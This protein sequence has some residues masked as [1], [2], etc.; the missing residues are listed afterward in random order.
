MNN[1]KLTLFSATNLV[2]ANIIGA[3]IF[4]ISGYTLGSVPSVFGLLIIW[5]IGG[6]LALCGALVYGELSSIMPKSGGEYYY[7]SRIYHPILGFLSGFISLTAGF[8]APVAAAS[9]AFGKYLSAVIY[10]QSE[11][12]LTKILAIIIIIILS[13]VHSY[14]LSLGS[15]IQNVLTAI[16][17]S[18]LFFFVISGLIITPNP[19]NISI[20]PQKEDWNLILSSGFAVSLIYISFAYSGWNAAAYMSEEVENPT[21]NVSKA[22]FIGTSMVIILYLLVNYVFVYTSSI[23]ELQNKAE[24]GDIAARKI[25]GEQGGKIVST[26]IACALTSAI[27]A[28][29]MA[30]PRVIQ[31]MGK[32]FP[33]FATFAKNNSRGIPAFAIIAQSSLS[34]L[35]VL[36]SELSN[37]LNYIGFTLSIFTFLTVLGLL[38]YRFKNPYSHH[39][40]KTPIYPV[41]PLLFLI[42]TAWMIIYNFI[43]KPF[44]SLI[45]LATLILGIIIYF[46]T[47]QHKVHFHPKKNL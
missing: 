2:V 4:T 35:V 16:K 3:G 32:D 11:D 24:V 1:N 5:F 20:L 44:E 41:P 9:L 14:S 26:M 45:G 42:L 19:Q 46:L 22:L 36:S 7:L 33:I 34:L 37:I 23:T 28:M 30:G 13:I 25:F 17:I 6:I 10:G 18:L 12:T 43:V 31:A 38:I 40:V 21:K 8:A 47:G 15:K 39:I 27:S 29:I